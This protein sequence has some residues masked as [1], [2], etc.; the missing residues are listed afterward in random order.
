MRYYVRVDRAVRPL[1]VAVGE[2]LQDATF[3]VGPWMGRGDGV[4]YLVGQLVA[5]RCGSGET[6]RQV[7]VTQLGISPK[8]YRDRFKSTG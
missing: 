8:A 4:A 7:F 3:A 5:A 1:Q 2:R 6:L